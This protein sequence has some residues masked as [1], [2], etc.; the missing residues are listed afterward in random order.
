MRENPKILISILTYN[1]VD[2]VEDC[3][4]SIK[5]QTSKNF[6][7]FVFDNNSTDN[8]KEVVSKYKF[9]EFIQVGRNEGYS[10]GNNFAYKYFKTSYPKEFIMLILNPDSILDI[11]F[12]DEVTKFIQ[13]EP[14][15]DLANPL[16][17]DRNSYHSPNNFFSLTFTSIGY[18]VKNLSSNIEKTRF[19]NGCCMLINLKKFESRS[20]FK[21]YFLYFEDTQLS[22]YH[23]IKNNMNFVIHK[24]YVEHNSSRDSYLPYKVFY[25][26]RNRF[27][28]ILDTYNKYFILLYFPFFLFFRTLILG[29]L[30]LKLRGKYPYISHFKGN[31]EGLKYFFKKF[32]I[33]KNGVGFIQTLKFLFFTKFKKKR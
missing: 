27:R 30:I 22:I 29:T 31:Y 9:V 10:G 28:Y 16:I 12:V 17:K 21:D 20:L 24:T 32:L 8:I 7:C 3:L 4:L 25:C 33:E 14:N 18:E 11:N 26:E 5:N 1:S 13:L 2:V 15:F 6:K 23:A 19:V